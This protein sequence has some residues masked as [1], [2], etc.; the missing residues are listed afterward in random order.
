MHSDGISQYGRGLQVF[1]QDRYISPNL[2][3]CLYKTE[4]KHFHQMALY[5]TLYL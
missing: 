4:P 3:I 5:K 2:P 1:H